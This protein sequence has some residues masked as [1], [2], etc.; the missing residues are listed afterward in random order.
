MS[1]VISAGRIIIQYHQDRY[2]YRKPQEAEAG[3]LYLHKNYLLVAKKQF[4]PLNLRFEM[5]NCCCPEGDEQQRPSSKNAFQGE[6][7]GRKMLRS[8]PYNNSF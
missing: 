2:P 8:A 5:G 7:R 1:R 3:A 6:V 4:L